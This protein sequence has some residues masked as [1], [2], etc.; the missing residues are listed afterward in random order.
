M[1]C[2]TGSGAY[3]VDMLSLVLSLLGPKMKEFLHPQVGSGRE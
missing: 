3:I 2:R 1:L